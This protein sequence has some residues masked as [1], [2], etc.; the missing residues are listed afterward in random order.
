MRAIGKLVE[1]AFPYVLYNIVKP[2]FALKNVY[3]FNYFNY[4]Y[5]ILCVS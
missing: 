4:I 1:M 2:P 3:L 5:I